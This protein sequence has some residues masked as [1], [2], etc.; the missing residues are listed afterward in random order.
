MLSRASRPAHSHALPRR[1][2]RGMTMV[3]CT[4]VLTVFLIMLFGMFEYCRFLLVLH[5]TNNAARDG[6]RYAS[7]NVDKP[8]TF[9][10]ADYT[11]GAGKVFH[12]I[13]RYTKERMGGVHGNLT[14]FR[15]AAFAVDQAGL[16][17]TPPVIR[18]KTK[19]TG[20]PPTYP[21]PY[22]PA[23]PNAVPWN[24]VPFPD[25]LAVQIDGY[26]KPLL[27]NFLLMPTSIHVNI[28]AMA[29]GEG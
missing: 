8:S 18:P 24:Q 26:Y 12:S 10:T 22:N 9:P 27:P 6:A 11:D 16:D 14:G 5:V 7:V 29:G 3:E 2:R 1:P 4:L 23:D 19:S 21:D 17:L 15:V 25:R 28:T 13:Q 20:S